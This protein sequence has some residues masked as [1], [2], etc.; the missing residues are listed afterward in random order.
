MQFIN[1][2]F[3][4]I[5]FLH[6]HTHTHIRTHTHT[7]RAK[8]CIHCKSVLAGSVGGKVS[9]PPANSNTTFSP[10]LTHSLTHSPT[11]SLTHSLFNFFNTQHFW[12]GGAGCRDAR[13]L[14]R[15]DP[16][17]YKILASG[18]TS[19]RKSTRVGPKKKPKE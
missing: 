4:H 9:K 1:A 13:K 6:T 19:S 17:K 8:E 3:V 14:N 16:H 10:A 15:N 11:H 7:H 18:K 2:C 5:S 12:E